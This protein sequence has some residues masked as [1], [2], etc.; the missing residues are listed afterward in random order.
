MASPIIIGFLTGI[1]LGHC[2]KVLI[3]VR[4]MSIALVGTIAAGVARAD[5]DWSIALTAGEVVTALQIGYLIGIGLRSFIVA[6]K[7][8]SS[9]QPP[10]PDPGGG[11]AVH[12][13][14]LP[15][16]CSRAR[17]D[18]RTSPRASNVVARRWRPSV[19]ESLSCALTSPV[20]HD[21]PPM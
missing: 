11:S 8:R 6:G 4:V 16:F 13:L 9:I 3:L 15:G 12:P 21:Y 17:S 2:F 20:R 19:A 18:G 7:G 1:A 14:T 5:S 10:G